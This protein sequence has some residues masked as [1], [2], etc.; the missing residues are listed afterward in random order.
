MCDYV[1]RYD[2]RGSADPF[3]IMFESRRYQ[4]VPSTPPFFH[5][6]PISNHYESF[7][8]EVRRL[9]A[10]EG[11]GLPNG[12]DASHL[13][14]YS[15]E[16]FVQHKEAIDSILS[17]GYVPDNAFLRETLSSDYP[18]IRMY[19]LE[20]FEGSRWSA[21]SDLVPSVTFTRNPEGENDTTPIL[22]IEFGNSGIAGID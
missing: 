10:E 16:L 21:K 14:R 4:V 5:S 8:R 15:I 12:Y 18:I 1:S 19:E 20:K 13:W 6:P 17:L 3:V 7:I 11:G 9:A 2:F 22:R